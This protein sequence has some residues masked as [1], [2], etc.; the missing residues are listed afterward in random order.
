VDQE[1][2]DPR[3]YAPLL[4]LGGK[5][6]PAPTW[7][8]EAVE[9]KPERSTVEVAGATIETLAWGER[10]RPGI[11]FMHGNGAHADWWS[12][13]APFFAAQYRVAAVSW[14][15]MGGSDWRAH[16]KLDNFVAE[17]LTAA[18]AT[19]LFSAAEKPVFVGHSFGGVPTIAAG[20]A[21]GD[22]LRAAVIIDTP[23]WSP[24]E[25]KRR[26]E[27]RK[28]S[29][30]PRPNRIYPSFNAALARFRLAPA[31][32]CENDFFVDFIARHSLKHVK[33]DAGEGWTWKFDP[34]MW[35]QF[36]LPD[37]ALELNSMRCPFALMWGS[38]SKLMSG[39]LLDYVLSIAPKET[40]KIEVPDAEH[41][42]MIDQPLAFVAA[43]RGLLAGWPR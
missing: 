29:R 36:E 39:K 18:E 20:I 43:L 26:R 11:L 41:H 16:Y 34:F 12:P 10:G 3:L 8:R 14:S 40:P 24:E 28:A 2:K 17:A 37:L 5:E 4:R 30:E 38:R 15:G 35:H 23:L 9:Q 22:R 32:L 33:N 19:G 31:Q 7:F 1:T 13:I 6:P 42:V 25:R 27:R 21:H